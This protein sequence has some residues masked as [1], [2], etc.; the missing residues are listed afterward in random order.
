MI[1]QYVRGPGFESRLGPCDIEVTFGAQCGSMLGLGA[2]KGLSRQFQHGSEQ[3]RGQ[4][5]F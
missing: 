2:A 5:L 3:I 4:I 1:A